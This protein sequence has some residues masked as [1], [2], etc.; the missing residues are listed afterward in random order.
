MDRIAYLSIKLR[1]LKLALKI[2]ILVY[3]I[4]YGSESFEATSNN[5]CTSLDTLEDKRAAA[6]KPFAG[7]YTKVKEGTKA[8]DYQNFDDR[9]PDNLL[10]IQIPIIHITELDFEK[11]IDGNRA[12][13]VSGGVGDIFQ[14]RLSTTKEEVIEKIVKNM[15]HVLRETRMQKYL[16]P[17]VCVPMLLGIVGGPEHV[18]TMIVQQMCAKG[19]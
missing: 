6:P 4:D 16:M 7:E 17:S 12:I 8:K 11:D 13:F 18:E 14:A 5:V 10:H 19:K 1:L 15:T 2:Y 9:V 3:I